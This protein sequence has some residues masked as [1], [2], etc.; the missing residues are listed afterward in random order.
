MKINELLD[1]IKF[2]DMVLPEFQR[3]YVWNKEDA[4]QLMVSLFKDYPT[5]SLLF[6][7]T[8]NPP[9]LKN[10]DL[11]EDM[12]GTTQVILDGQ[13][14]LTTLYLLM[15]NSIP[16]YY[17]E[18]DISS[19][20]TNLYFNL[21]TSEFQYYKPKTMDDNP[22]WV[23]VVDCF[24]PEIEIDP[25]TLVGIK[26]DVTKDGESYFNLLKVVNSNFNTLLSIAH[27]TYPIQVVPVNADIDEAIDIFDRVNSQGTKL[28]DAELALAHVCGKWSQAREVM[29]E[30]IRKLEEKDFYFDLVFM[31]RCLTG[32]ITGRAEFET[33]HDT[34]ED[35]LKEG[36]KQLDQIL[37]Y[38]INILPANAFIDSTK[39]L[40]TTNILVPIV[41][42][43]SKNNRKF[44]NKN[45][46]KKFIHWMY[47]AHIWG[48]YSG[49]TDQ[50]LDKDISI[51]TKNE[52][53][54]EGLVDEIIDMRG[55]IEVKPSDIDS[56]GIQNPLFK[57]SYIASKSLGALDWCDGIPL[58]KTT[59]DD[60]QLQFHHIFPKSLL[61]KH[62]NYSEKTYRDQKMVNEI[63][64][65]AFLTKNSNWDIYNREPSKYL[66]K[67]QKMYPGE[68]EK[69]FIPTQ[70]E[71]WKIGR[72][73][74]FMR[75]RRELMSDGINN[76]MD[77]LLKDE[78]TPPED[79][80]EDIIANGENDKV[81]FKSTIR[82]DVKNQQVNKNLQKVIAKTIAG[83]MNTHGGMLFIG[84]ADDCSIYGIENDIKTLNHKD[85][86]GFQQLLAQLI[87]NY[88]GA[89][90][91]NYINHEF[92]E[93]EGKY[94]CVLKI[95][96]TPKP[97]FLNDKNQTEFY[98]RVTATTRSLGPKETNEYISNK[99]D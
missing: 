69:Q 58:G 14:R 24:N 63:A 90:Y 66:K 85:L 5:G 31:T 10:Y 4:K 83:F 98:I 86:D 59:G 23:K 88:I 51:I 71:L 61:Y 13:Q 52:N 45:E 33:I 15:R 78:P 27:K 56:R 35:N 57:M 17:K 87:E 64:N 70:S 9:E 65:R 42:Y 26:I 34:P 96:E 84:V 75:K 19:N 76:L 12:N 18:Y 54:W 49:Q 41:V 3:E 7:K 72:Y 20:P 92:K 50:R 62:P 16:P 89:Q 80:I 11:P 74:D 82:W 95:E 37:D 43:L 67:I 25:V 55:R 22:L 32:V 47:A 94:V 77:S 2:Q 29:K 81:E 40:G 60:Y 93:I 30:K 53:P 44:S 91:I 28:S 38:L 99:Y 68:L 97:I 39:D 73:E 48:R 8:D 1:G 79:L 46:M 6:W 36:W 21:E